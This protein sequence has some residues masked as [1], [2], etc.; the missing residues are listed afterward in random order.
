VADAT[1]AKSLLSTEIQPH[2][3]LIHGRLP[4]GLRYVLLPNK[5]PPERFEAHLE[6]HVGSVDERTDE[7]VGIHGGGSG[8]GLQKRAVD[9]GP[10]T[11]VVEW[12]PPSREEPWRRVDGLRR[13]A[14]ARADGQARRKGR[15]GG[16]WCSAR[17]PGSRRGAAR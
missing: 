17:Q 16:G 11:G 5:T 3:E 2:G 8:V 1:D 13:S 9:W 10:V 7:Q 6:M 15:G 4:N 12:S 14:G